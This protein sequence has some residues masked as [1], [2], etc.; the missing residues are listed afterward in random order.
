MDIPQKV[1]T[2]E[3]NKRKYLFITDELGSST[4]FSLSRSCAAEDIPFELHYLSHENCQNLN[5]LKKSL[6]ENLCKQ[7]MGTY[8][9]ILTSWDTLEP[10]SQL[11]E[12]SGFSASEM[13]KVGFG[14]KKKNVYC[15]CCQ[16]LNK[17]ITESVIACVYCG[18]ELHVSEH[19]SR[20]LNAYLGSVVIKGKGSR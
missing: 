4:A 17:H 1:P 11:A 20:R 6:E 12:K 10:L 5:S 19:Y 2:L 3:A 13:A 14:E 15:S 9:Y 8:L 16:Q 7:R 18:H